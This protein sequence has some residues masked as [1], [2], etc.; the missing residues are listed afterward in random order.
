M[1]E[2]GHTRHGRHEVLFGLERCEGGDGEE[3]CKSEGM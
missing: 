2:S 1:C 3:R